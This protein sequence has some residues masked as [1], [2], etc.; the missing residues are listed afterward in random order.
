M[1]F[2]GTELVKSDIGLIIVISHDQ[3]TSK[4]KQTTKMIREEAIFALEL[5]NMSIHSLKEKKYKCEKHY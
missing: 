4:R 1:Q 3:L 2:F 5:Q